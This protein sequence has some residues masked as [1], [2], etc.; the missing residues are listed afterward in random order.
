M[1]QT[2]FIVGFSELKDLLIETYKIDLPRD[3]IR[4]FFAEIDNTLLLH[5]YLNHKR[6][7]LL[8]SNIHQKRS[9]NVRKKIALKIIFLALDSADPALF[10]NESYLLYGYFRF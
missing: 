9:P 6:S 2:E 7:V 5:D 4:L 8:S 1:Q 3:Q 10:L